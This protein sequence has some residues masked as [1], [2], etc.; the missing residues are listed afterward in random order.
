MFLSY[1]EGDLLLKLRDYRNLNIYL[2]TA[3]A[4]NI[5]SIQPLCSKEIAYSHFL[6]CMVDLP[7]ARPR[8]AK[9]YRPN[10]CVFCRSRFAADGRA[11]STTGS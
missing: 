8:I 5:G 2:R 10:C 4:K 11:W 7:G 6:N 3:L 1:E 9:R